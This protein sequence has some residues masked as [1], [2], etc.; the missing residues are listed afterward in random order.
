M[1]INYSNR[2]VVFWRPVNLYLRYLIVTIYIKCR[3]VGRGK[4]G[5][6]PVL[7]SDPR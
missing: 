4:I 6:D 1:K 5:S 7:G 3:A 2:L